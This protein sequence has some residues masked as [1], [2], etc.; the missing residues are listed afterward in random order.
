MAEGA[1][2]RRGFSL[3]ELLVVIA[4]IAVLIA[5]LLPAIQSSREQARRVQCVKNLQQI[6]LALSSYL[7]SHHVY[8]PGVVDLKGPVSNVP[9]GYAFGWSVQV[10]PYL[11]ATALFNDFNFM[12]G[13]YEQEND[14][15]RNHSLAIFLCPSD[16][17]GNTATNYT[18]C[19]HDVEA[20]IDGDN[21][22]VFFLNSHVAR[23]DLVDG[24]AYTLLVG[25]AR[26]SRPGLGWAVGNSSSLRNAGMPIN[27]EERVV[28]SVP[29]VRT[30][31]TIYITPDE[32]GSLVSN[33]QLPALYVG[34][35]SSHHPNG[36][37]F[38]LGD[39][40][41][42]FLKDRIDPDVYRALAHRSDGTLISA[43]EL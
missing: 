41:V 25:E 20:P 12:M 21:H 19:H 33:G 11:E 36:S 10:L 13:V 39:G 7:S 3:V 8:P 28:A 38:L 40:S 17:F 43:D 9:K 18:G 42:R 27:A 5:L 29:M 24:P 35:F 6:G 22:G 4:V 15:A 30:Y 1:G 2:D 14:T 34:G 37:N 31:G 16:P 32:L 23:A 26:K